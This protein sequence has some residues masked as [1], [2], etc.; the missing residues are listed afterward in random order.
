MF[1]P[2]CGAE[3]TDDAKFCANC[4]MPLEI[5]TNPSTSSGPNGASASTSSVA[6]TKAGS[7]TMMAAVIIEIIAC[8]FA[9][10]SQFMSQL[11]MSSAMSNLVKLMGESSLSSVVYVSLINPGLV[12]TPSKLMSSSAATANFWGWFIPC[13]VGVVLTVV[14]TIRVVTAHISTTKKVGLLDRIPRRLLWIGPAL[15]V[16]S[17]VIMISG[18]CLATSSLG[19]DSFVVATPWAYIAVTSAVIAF[20]LDLVNHKKGLV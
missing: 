12:T 8:S 10:V 1:C 18:I 3:N 2:K 17:A 7:S 15:I 20:I 19:K 5:R 14:L 4:G 13:L 9:V 6:G 11:E 16:W